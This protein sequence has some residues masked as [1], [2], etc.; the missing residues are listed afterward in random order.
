MAKISSIDPKRRRRQ[1]QELAAEA[2]RHK[3]DLVAWLRGHFAEHP[4][5]SKSYEALVLAEVM[6]LAEDPAYL[7]LCKRPLDFLAEVLATVEQEVGQACKGITDQVVPRTPPAG[8]RKP[9]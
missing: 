7:W 3:D 4:A 9:K 6:R 2:D 8:Y 1:G 5:P